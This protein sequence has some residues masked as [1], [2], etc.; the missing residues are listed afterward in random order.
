MQGLLLLIVNT[1]IPSI[2]TWNKD[3]IFFTGKYSDMDSQWFSNV[4]VL[5][6]LIFNRRHLHYS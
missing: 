1:Q 2:Y 6:V 4:G 5:I 3:F